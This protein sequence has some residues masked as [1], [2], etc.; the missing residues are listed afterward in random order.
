M[1]LANWQAI[2]ALASSLFSHWQIGGLSKWLGKTK[3]C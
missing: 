2:C 3:R 1:Y